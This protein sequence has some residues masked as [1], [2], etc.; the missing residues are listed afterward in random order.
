MNIPG[1][2][3]NTGT[4]DRNA[5]FFAVFTKDKEGQTATTMICG[6]LHNNEYNHILVFLMQI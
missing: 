1:K 3:F 2:V 4:S 5:P 6:H